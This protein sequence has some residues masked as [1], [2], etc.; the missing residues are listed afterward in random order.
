MVATVPEGSGNTDETAYLGT[1]ARNVFFAN[2]NIITEGDNVTR[3]TLGQ[4]LRIVV[5]ACGECLS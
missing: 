5:L 3:R 2:N 4:P 1:A